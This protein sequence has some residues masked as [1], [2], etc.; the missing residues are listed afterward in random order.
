MVFFRKSNGHMVVAEDLYN[1]SYVVEMFKI[2]R[3]CKCDCDDFLVC[4]ESKDWDKLFLIM[5]EDC[6]EEV[7][8]DHELRELA[9]L[10]VFGEEV[11]KE[12]EKR[13]EEKVKN[14]D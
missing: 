12:I 14:L 5:M 9:L 1:P 11:S 3:I 2:T 8:V 7:V 4:V 6:P 10:E 13:H